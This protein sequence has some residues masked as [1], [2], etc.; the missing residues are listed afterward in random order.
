MHF[1]NVFNY[2]IELLQWNRNKYS[3][4]NQ[5]STLKL[6]QKMVELVST[7]KSQIYHFLI[8]TKRIPLNCMSAISCQFKGGPWQQKKLQK[9]EKYVQRSCL[10]C[11]GLSII[12]SVLCLQQ[13]R[14]DKIYLNTNG[15]GIK[16]ASVLYEYMI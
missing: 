4:L 2:R 15:K 7:M 10:H 8:M 5:K 13:I 16:V 3:K 9:R 12:L 1:Q 14:N 6:Q 11:H